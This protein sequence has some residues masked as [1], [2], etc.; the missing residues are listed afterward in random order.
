VSQRT[1]EGSSILYALSRS[2]MMLVGRDVVVTV[3]AP[4]GAT[5]ACL[6]GALECAFE[7]PGQEDDLLVVELGAGTVHVRPAQVARIDHW[8]VAA[9]GES[10]ASVAI[11]FHHG[12]S[13]L[14]QEDLSHAFT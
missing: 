6:D 12:L 8:S 3:L 2:L 10:F 4:N 9:A 11:L 13:V 7:F 1:T 5:I 14:I